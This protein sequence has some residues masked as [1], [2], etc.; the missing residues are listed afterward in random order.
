MADRFTRTFARFLKIEALTGVALL[1]AAATALVISNSPWSATYLGFWETEVGLKLGPLDFTRPVRLWINDGLMT[2]F[3]FVVALELKRALVIGE[4]RQMR[5]AA[6]S[7]AGALGGMIVPAALFILLLK[8]APGD[9]GWGVVMATD[10]AFVI[11]AV[12]LLGSRLPPGLRLFLLSL[13]V[14]DDIGAI[15]VVAVVYGGTLSWTA[16]ALAGA[17]VGVVAVAARIGVRA[18][19]VYFVLG[20]F[21]WLALDQSGVHP[22]LAGVVLGLMTPTRGWVSDARLHLIL[23]RVLSYPPGEHWS[24][25][26]ADRGDLRRAGT[27]A[28]ET[29]SPVERLEMALHPWSAFAIMP[30]FALANAGVRIPEVAILEPVSIAIFAG[31]VVGK[32]VGVL[33]FSWIACLL[34]IASRP[35]ELRWAL[36]AGSAPLT[37]IGFT[38]SLFIAGLAF[39]PPLLDAAKIGILSASVASGLIGIG[40]LFLLSRSGGREAAKE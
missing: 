18:V 12:A 17:G 33:T 4:L 15:T 5:I 9:H 39:A 6:F 16:I 30:L 2:F 14:F 28:R 36:V 35:P 31:L 37:G 25:D 21:V 27:A 32:P 20:A 1:G 8:G 22:T 23:S 40:A 26:T 24:G 13:A 10:T 7:L 38:M 34:R 3:F 29:L 11:G 19:K